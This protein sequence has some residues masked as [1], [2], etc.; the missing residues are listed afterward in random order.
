MRQAKTKPQRRKQ[1]S[2]SPN[3]NAGLENSQKSIMSKKS[4][5]NV[6]QLS[7]RG[8]LNSK[9]IPN[10][11]QQ[12]NAKCTSEKKSEKKLKTDYFSITSEND[13]D[14]SQDDELCF[15]DCPKITILDIY[16]KIIKNLSVRSLPDNVNFRDKEK[17]KMNN[18][19]TH[20]LVGTG[21]GC[22]TLIVT[23]QPGAGKTLLIN[24]LLDS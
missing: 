22:S 7:K 17:F 9:I 11:L 3:K 2:N 12:D 19:L 8:I 10:G 21:Q 24:N 23:G 1:A 20:F 15:I 16:K 14:L 4:R 6:T 18:F 13:Q 5:K